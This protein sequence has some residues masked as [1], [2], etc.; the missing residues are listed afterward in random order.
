MEEGLKSSYLCLWLLSSLHKNR[1]NAARYFPFLCQV[2]LA[3]ATFICKLWG[4]EENMKSQIGT[5]LSLLPPPPSH[6]L[7]PLSLPTPLLALLIS[8]MPRKSA[9]RQLSAPLDRNK[10]NVPISEQ[11]RRRVLQPLFTFLALTRLLTGDRRVEKHQFF[12]ILTLMQTKKKSVPG[13]ERGG[14]KAW[15]INKHRF[16]FHN[17]C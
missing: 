15:E 10:S 9:P 6:G 7:P 4:L 11:R 17:M 3:T 12:W 8:E 14:E 13:G 2:T 1:R 16:D 5:S